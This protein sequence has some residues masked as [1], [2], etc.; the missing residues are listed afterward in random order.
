M[1]RKECGDELD[2]NIVEECGYSPD[3]CE[4]CDYN[5]DGYC[6]LLQVNIPDDEPEVGE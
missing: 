5:L 4:F 2:R 1:N 3:G 6:S